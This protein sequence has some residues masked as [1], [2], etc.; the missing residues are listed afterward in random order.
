MTHLDELRRIYTS[1]DR[2]SPSLTFDK[3]ASLFSVEDLEFL[4]TD[5]D[6]L[7]MTYIADH[8]GSPRGAELRDWVKVGVL[9]YIAKRAIKVGYTAQRLSEVATMAARIEPGRSPDDWAQ[10]L[11]RRLVTVDSLEAYE[12]CGLEVEWVHIGIELGLQFEVVKGFRDCG[13]PPRF[14][15]ER[16][17]ACSQEPDT[18]YEW[19]RSGVTPEVAASFM[20]NN[21]SCDEAVSWL[22]RGKLPEEVTE[23][24][25]HGVSS[26]VT[27]AK[28][29]QPIYSD[30]FRRDGDHFF[31]IKRD[32]QMRVFNAVSALDLPSVGQGGM[33]ASSWSKKLFLDGGFIVVNGY[34]FG[35]HSYTRVHGEKALAFICDR[36]GVRRPNIRGTQ[37]PLPTQEELE[38]ELRIQRMEKWNDLLKANRP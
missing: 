37:P 34:G 20:E 5:H 32:F 35:S 26:I 6:G 16:I 2:H 33:F 7:K 13:L 11:S 14:V 19:Y 36:I 4:L 23:I 10:I 12:N 29:R 27:S 25:R 17:T 28:G 18:V 31:A 9:A 38:E 8:E 15:T 21:V 30:A 24:L 22:H 3:V 1:I